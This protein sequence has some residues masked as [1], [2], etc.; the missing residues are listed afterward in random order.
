MLRAV[1]PEKAVRGR[2][3]AVV[4][5]GFDDAA[6][7]AVDQHGDADQLARDQVRRCGKIDAGK[8]G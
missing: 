2:I 7:D 1:G 5:L 4:G 8:D 3:F 6:A